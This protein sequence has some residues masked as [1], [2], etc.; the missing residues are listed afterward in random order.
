MDKEV[1]INNLIEQCPKNNSI[2]Q[3]YIKSF[4]IINDSKYKNILCTISGGSDSDIVLDICH[5]C[6][7]ENKIKY[8]WFDT[9]LEFQA[10]KVHL[11]Y[12]EKKY[13]IA[14]Q[15]YKSNIPIPLSA[16][17]YGQPFLSKRISEY[18][19][20]LQKHNFNWEDDK[21]ETLTTKYPNCESA[22]RWWCNAHGENSRF[23]IE[24]TPY[25]KDFLINTPPNFKISNKC[26]EY[27]KKKVLHQALKDFSS[28]L[29]IY[30]VRKSEG[31]S[32]STAYKNCYSER[33]GKVDELRPIFW[34]TEQD[35]LDYENTFQIQHS[36]CYSL[37]GMSRTGCAGC[38]FGRN[39]EEELNIIEKYEPKLFKAA[40][41]IFHDS[42]QYTKQFYMFRQEQKLAKK[43]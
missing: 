20:R 25:L 14:I 33:I 37:Y 10:T 41:N 28:D 30:G 2:V 24:H 34:F 13:D 35:K 11:E 31:G 27:S 43:I 19:S 17:K 39:F 16:I 29:N 7:I 5:K 36:D 42:Y 1:I 38:P 18:I 32:R 9:G 26:C 6:D 3:A 21:F 15:R 12:L 22:L 4:K 23:N 40:C 8:V